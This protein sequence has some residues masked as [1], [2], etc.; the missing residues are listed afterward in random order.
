MR[1]MNLAVLHTTHRGTPPVDFICVG[2]GLLA[3][4][5]YASTGLPSAEAPVAMMGKLTAYSCGGS[6]GFTGFPLSPRCTNL[7][8]RDVYI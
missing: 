4:G 6:P 1:E 7:G 8:N 5:S 3:R 2:A